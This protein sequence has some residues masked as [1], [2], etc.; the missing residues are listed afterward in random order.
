M[1]FS[2]VQRIRINAEQIWKKKKV[3]INEFEQSQKLGHG[4]RYQAVSNPILKYV[5]LSS[6]ERSRGYRYQAVALPPRPR[7]S[8]AQS[9]ATRIHSITAG[10]GPSD[11]GGS[12]ALPLPAERFRVPILP[13]S[14]SPLAVRGVAGRSP[15]PRG[16]ELALDQLG[17]PHARGPRFGVSRRR[18]IQHFNITIN[19]ID[20]IKNQWPRG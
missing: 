1:L 12:S 19:A 10:A 4:Y 9:A 17:W 3:I 18:G 13:C 7:R 6:K 20:R 11:T 8:A 5:K 16:R 2:R 14:P 15:G